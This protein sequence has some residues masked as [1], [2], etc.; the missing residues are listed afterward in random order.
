MTG[1]QLTEA[2]IAAAM[3]K[4]DAASV[5]AV[6]AALRS[7][8]GWKMPQTCT[9]K[10]RCT[11]GAA[12]RVIRSVGMSARVGKCRSKSPSGWSNLWRRRMRER[13]RRHWSKQ[14]LRDRTY[15]GEHAGRGTDD[16]GEDAAAGGAVMP[17]CRRR[18]EGALVSGPPRCGPFSEVRANYLLAGGISLSPQQLGVRAIVSLANKTTPALWHTATIG[19]R[20]KLTGHLRTATPLARLSGNGSAAPMPLGAGSG[21]LLQVPR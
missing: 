8:T 12:D 15:E 5:P 3:A 2:M 18:C 9:P 19:A 14:I 11:S 6:T 7:R 16:P 21:T 10:G 17:S 20:P 1:V 13:A 4:A